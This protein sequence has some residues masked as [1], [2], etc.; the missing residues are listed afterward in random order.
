[1]N[2]VNRQEGYM[3]LEIVGFWAPV[4]DPQSKGRQPAGQ[5]SKPGYFEP[6]RLSARHALNPELDLHI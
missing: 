2:G 1:M 6:G 5:T 3:E 4:S